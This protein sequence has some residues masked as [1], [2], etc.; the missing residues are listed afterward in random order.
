MVG[1]LCIGVDGG[2]GEIFCLLVVGVLVVENVGICVGMLIGDVCVD[3]C[4]VVVGNGWW[5]W[6]VLVIVG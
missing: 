3:Y 5:L 6:I 2:F 4:V 1:C